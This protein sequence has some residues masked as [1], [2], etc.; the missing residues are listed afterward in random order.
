VNGRHAN[1]ASLVPGIL[2]IAA[3]I[4][5]VVAVFA[6]G[7]IGALRG[8]TFHLYAYTDEARGIL[9]GSEVRLAGQKVGLVTD[10]QF[11]P[12]STDSAKRIRLSLEILENH[13]DQFRRDSYAQIRS[14]GTLLGAPV[15][16]VT[17][18]TSRTPVLEDWAL[19]QSREQLDVEAVT[20]EVA[21]AS[22]QFPAIIANMKLVAQQIR[23]VTRSLD[24]TSPDAE[25]PVSVVTGR[26]LSLGRRMTDGRGTIASVLRDADPLMIR[27]RRAVARADSARA[28]LAASRGSLGKLQGDSTIIR[29]L[30][31]VRNELSIVSALLS[32]SRGTAGRVLNDSA[33]VMQVRQLERELGATI[34][35]LKRDPGRYIA[36]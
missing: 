3:M 23:G 11:R 21:I 16:Y 33:L 10:I 4:A 35:D 20:S 15:V 9:R 5:F 32:E 13:R 1:W 26:A 28:L 18:G 19:L 12:A 34:A 8:D 30:A 17:P 22:R 36:F 2:A 31:D 24:A 29:T 25:I 7:R 14:G 6:F 27:A